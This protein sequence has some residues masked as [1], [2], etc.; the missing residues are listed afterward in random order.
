MKCAFHFHFWPQNEMHQWNARKIELRVTFCIS[1]HATPFGLRK[2]PPLHGMADLEVGLFESRDEMESNDTEP[3][4]C[5][6]RLP[7]PRQEWTRSGQKWLSSLS[8]GQ[9]HRSASWF[10]VSWLTTFSRVA[11]SVPPPHHTHATRTPTPFG[12]TDP[13]RTEKYLPR[14]LAEQHARIQHLRTGPIWSLIWSSLSSW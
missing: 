4:R 12:T 11:N 2:F 13:L 7:T 6:I 10:A 14:I 5:V 9:G 3:T 1:F 8:L